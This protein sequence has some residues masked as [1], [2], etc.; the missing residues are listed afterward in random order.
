MKKSLIL[1]MLAVLMLVLAGCSCKHE[2][3]KLNN[4]VDA[5]CVTDGYT[6]DVIC[7]ECGEV[8][9]QGAAVKA[10]GH[11]LAEPMN[12][13]E[14]TCYNSGYT[15]D[16]YCSFCGELVAAG[17]A[18]EMLEHVP[19]ELE[20]VRESTCDESGYTGDV[21][22]K[23]CGDIVE[24]G[25]YIDRLPHTPGEPKDGY[26]AT[27][28]Y[29]GYTGDIYC[30]VCGEW[31]DYGEYTERLE[32][33]PAEPDDAYEA[34]CSSQGYTGTIYC[35]VCGDWL[36]SGEYTEKLEHTPGEREYVSEATCTSSG[37][38]GDLYCAVCG[39][40][41]ES[42]EYTDYLPHTPGE[43]ANAV[44]ANCAHDGYTGDS[45]CT[46]C[47][48]NVYGEV[49]PKSEHNFADNTCADCGWMKAGLYIDGVMQFSWEEM[50]N[51]S[52][53]TVNENNGLT[54]VAKS[55][56]GLLVVE[57]GVYMNSD[58][59]FEGCMLNGVYLPASV[60]KIRY[61]MFYMSTDLEEVRC[62]GPISYVDSYAF[63][64]CTS[65][66]SFDVPEGTVG[67]NYR[68]F[69]GCTALESVTLPETLTYID[70]SAFEECVKLSGVVLPSSIE[71]MDDYVFYN[72]ASLTELVLPEGIE[73]IGVDFLNG[74]GVTE[75][76]LPGTMTSI[77]RQ[78]N[79]GLVKFDM[80][81][82][83]FTGFI[84]EGFAYCTVL[85]EL[86]LPLM[87]EYMSENTF[88]DCPSL[89]RLVLPDG[90]NSIRDEWSDMSGNTALTEVVWPAS[91]IDGTCLAVLPNLETIYF[92]GT[93][94]QWDLT[95]SKDLFAGKNI[96][97]NYTGE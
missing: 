89:K 35:E 44:E 39:D 95:A 80:S 73:S 75:L 45:E 3:T 90:F 58:S 55:L 54:S 43:T 11:T 47:G 7:L 78:Q 33:T 14:A 83:Q 48:S 69:F 15:G 85:E 86:K 8:V 79:P 76:V 29:E 66:K 56:Y 63:E 53:V 36:A 19:G 1:V 26:E 70:E 40:W 49:I 20:N 91:L 25:E 4:A 27:C 84:S 50:L 9:T 41:M 38:T 46:V 37:Y 5:T 6:G 92:R 57:E 68:A 74:S 34:T 97:F 88:R 30:D 62:F 18:T 72:C 87:L 93:E 60:D 16:V 51:N 21:Y 31:V 42:G 61:R 96:V 23:L 28:S 65:L 81:A 52:Y 17:Q 13:R 59:L 71:W 24:Y 10:E 67:I 77:G 22:C 64:G 94:L 32:H 12:M 82:A 2:A